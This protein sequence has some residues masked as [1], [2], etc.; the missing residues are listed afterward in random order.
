LADIKAMVTQLFRLPNIV[1]PSGTVSI[2]SNHFVMSKTHR[3]LHT[4]HQSSQFN[5]LH[6]MK[7]KKIKARGETTTQAQ[8]QHQ[9][10]MMHITL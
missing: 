5:Q 2:V 4:E 8:S 10:F 7:K 9:T 1:L 3:D 6:N